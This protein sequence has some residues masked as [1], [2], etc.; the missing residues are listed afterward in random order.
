[1]PALSVA[2][3]EKRVADICGSSFM[4][5]AL[6]IIMIAQVFGSGDGSHSLLFLEVRL[7][8]SI[9]LSMVEIFETK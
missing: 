4:E 8:Y 3:Q 5:Q 1:M 6:Y 2:E 9:F 7:T